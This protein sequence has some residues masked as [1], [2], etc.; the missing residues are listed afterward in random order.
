MNDLNLINGTLV[1]KEG[2]LEADL[3]VKDGR[4]VEIGPRGSLAPAAET[5]DAAGKLVFPGM[6]DT[7]V[8]IRGGALDYREDFFS[9]TVAAAAGGVT[10]I[11]EMPVGKPPAC[12]EEGFEARRREMDE[13][14]AVDFCM[15][16]GAGADNLDQIPR[17]AALGAIGYKTFLMPPV[18]GREQE[19]YGLCCESEEALTTVM[20]RVRETGL[21]LACH[22]EL[23]EYVEE[24][25]RRMMATGRKDLKAFCDSRPPEAEL[26]AVRRVIASAEKT[27]CKVSICHVSLPETVELIAQGRARGVDIHGETCPQYLV[28]NDENAAFAGAFARMKPPLRPPE[29]ARRLL[30]DYAAGRLEITG[31][32]H[33]PYTYAEKTRNGDDIWH[34]FDG[35][36]GLELSLRLLLNKIVEG[37]LSYEA[38]AANTAETPAALFG[39]ADRK[40]RLEPGRDADLVLV[41]K[42]P[43]PEEPDIGRLFTKSR[44]SAVLYSR[45]ALSHRVVRTLVRGQTVFADGAFVGSKGFGQIIKPEIKKTIKKE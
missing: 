11:L 40:G 37:E 3:A 35:I 16:A 21:T 7:H 10:T 4:I 20:A 41:E 17:L 18:P 32:D 36:P 8:H 39:I 38:L 15:Y 31:S 23:N 30:A 27:G 9:G 5:L 6:I 13:L 25:A 43:E 45:T 24:T 12:T 2:C 44:E 19:F 22:S 28:Y 1:R 14:C 34:S 33:A 29:T 26:A 42:L